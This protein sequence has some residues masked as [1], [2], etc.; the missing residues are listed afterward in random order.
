ML[1]PALVT[2]LFF[3]LAVL[4]RYAHTRACQNRVQTHLIEKEKLQLRASG[5][6]SPRR[7]VPKGAILSTLRELPEHAPSAAPRDRTITELGV[8]HVTQSM[9]V[10]LPPPP[11]DDELGRS[12]SRFVAEDELGRSKS[13]FVT[14]RI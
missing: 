6:D 1:V 11:P 10:N 8:P 3:L 12:K 2:V 7:L 9:S 4:Y 13:R 14:D 5:G